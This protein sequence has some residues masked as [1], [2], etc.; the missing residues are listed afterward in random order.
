M[1]QT[2]TARQQAEQTAEMVGIKELCVI[3]KE[4]TLPSCDAA[5]SSQLENMLTETSKQG[6][7][8]SVDY[9]WRQQV[10][11]QYDSETH[12]G[13]INDYIIDSMASNTVTHTS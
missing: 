7:R 9:I 2:Q 5:I 10:A 12:A 8:T 4:Q 6:E 13:L 11:S 3:V 1:I